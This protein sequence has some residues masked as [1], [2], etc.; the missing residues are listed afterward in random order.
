M[1]IRK[2][3]KL[4]ELLEESGLTELE[5]SEGEESIRLSRSGTATAVQSH[6][7]VDLQ[8]PE[9][10]VGLT[11]DNQEQQPALDT[12]AVISPMV[13]TYYA[14]ANADSE[15]YVAL[16]S[17]VNVGD[18]LC[19]IEAMKIFNQVETEISGFVRKI[20]KRSGDP[21]EY[22]ETLFLIESNNP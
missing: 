9:L 18:T 5:I 7:L 13:G 21:V 15:P 6:P 19:V 16:G 1:D 10:P 17:E 8:A 4:I 3:K 20:L 14:A 2:V 11:Q 22:G 12:V